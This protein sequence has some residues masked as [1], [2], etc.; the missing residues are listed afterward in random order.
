MSIAI[1]VF[2]VACIGY[3]IY[4]IAKNDGPLGPTGS[5][6]GGVSSEPADGAQNQA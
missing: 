1:V 2:I 5:A 6:G 4:R 3:A